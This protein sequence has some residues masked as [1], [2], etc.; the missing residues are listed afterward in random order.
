L[1]I[2]LL[3][4]VALVEIQL[5]AAVVLAVCAL[6]LSLWLVPP[7]TQLRLVLVQVEQQ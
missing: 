4:V 3:L 7:L 2:W 6:V 1:N 5:A